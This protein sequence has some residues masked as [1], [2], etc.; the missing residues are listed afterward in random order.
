M[1]SR[2]IMVR[3]NYLYDRALSDTELSQVHTY[4][5]DK[6][7]IPVG[8]NAEPDELSGCILWLD[9]AAGVTKDTNNKVTVWQDQSGAGN[10]A[11]ASGST[12]PT[13]VEAGINNLPAMDFNGHHFALP[14]SLLRDVE[15]ADIFFVHVNP[16]G[17]ATHY[18]TLVMASQGENGSEYRLQMRFNTSANNGRMVLGGTRLDSESFQSV[19][20]TAVQF[21]LQANTNYITNGIFDYN[22]A[23]LT[24]KSNG[25]EL[26]TN[27]SFQT[28]GRTSDTDSQ[29][30]WLGNNMADT[31]RKFIGQI[32]EVIIFNR[33][34]AHAE[35]LQLENYLANKYGIALE[36]E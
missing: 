20:P 27:G 31:S 3:E 1:I 16:D 26:A 9:A 33:R 22:N 34:L 24:A 23:L 13:W 36:R 28:K 15:A 25:E 35:R 2:T 11:T 21:S 19:Y 7:G 18:Q 5:D 14:N 29:G 30:V 6:Y 32:A 8:R 17:A 10:H 4:L 12:M